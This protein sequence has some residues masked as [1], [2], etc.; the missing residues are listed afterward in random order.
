[1]AIG[2]DYIDPWQNAAVR[3]KAFVVAALV[4]AACLL[5]AREAV[6]CDCMRLAPLGPGVTSEVPFIFSGTAIEIVERNEHTT[7]LRSG[8]ATSTVRPLERRVVFRVI[9]G[10]RGVATPEF[11]VLAEISDCLFNFE[12]DRTYLVFARATAAGVAESNIC[13]RT[14]AMEQAT[15]VI[16]VLGP[17]AYRH[18]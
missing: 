16:R 4:A 11:S 15:S 2:R 10:W 17:P 9:T 14:S 7:A 18:P 1:M 8:G 5:P 13:T 6:A 12:L 3:M